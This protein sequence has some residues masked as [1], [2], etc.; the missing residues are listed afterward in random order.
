MKRKPRKFI[1]TDDFIINLHKSG[2]KEGLD[3]SDWPKEDIKEYLNHSRLS[4]SELKC[5]EIKEP[6][7]PTPWWE[8]LE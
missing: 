3:H 2:I 8:E 6:P 5:L 1:V 7:E 4:L